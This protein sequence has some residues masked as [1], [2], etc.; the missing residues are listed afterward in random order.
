MQMAKPAIVSPLGPR[1][2]PP[3]PDLFC[4]CLQQLRPP[5]RAG[6]WVSM[7]QVPVAHSLQGCP[8]AR[9]ARCWPLAALGVGS[10]GSDPGLPALPGQPVAWLASHCWAFR[11]YFSPYGGP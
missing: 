11:V 8:R 10:P 2:T 7:H 6:R 1:R 3:P 5:T 9:P 4:A